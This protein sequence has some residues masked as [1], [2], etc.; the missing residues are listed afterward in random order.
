[1]FF[2]RRRSDC[3]W[4]KGKD[5]LVFSIDHILYIWIYWHI[6]TL[7]S[8][9]SHHTH[10]EDNCFFP[11]NSVR[12]SKTPEWTKN[13]ARARAHTQQS[14][15]GVCQIVPSRSGRPKA[16]I[17]AHSVQISPSPH[18]Q[19][20]KDP[21]PTILSEKYTQK[22][23]AVTYSKKTKYKCQRVGQWLGLEAW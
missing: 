16:P 21:P 17:Y 12:K 8:N 6:H 10:W 3:S 9:Y 13:S 7:G 11:H 23:N 20:P 15:L 18:D 2:S 19:V 4:Y 5:P 22:I 14:A 1:M